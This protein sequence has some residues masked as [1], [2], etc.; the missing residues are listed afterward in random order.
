MISTEKGHDRYIKDF[1]NK[2][3]VSLSSIKDS[4]QRMQSYGIKVVQDVKESLINDLQEH[5]TLNILC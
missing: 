2:S 1:D 3:A 4:V 5:T